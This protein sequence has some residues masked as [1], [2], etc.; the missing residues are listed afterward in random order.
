MFLWQN[1]REKSKCACS[2]ASQGSWINLPRSQWQKI[3]NT[4]LSSLFCFRWTEGGKRGGKSISH[5]YLYSFSTYDAFLQSSFQRT[6]MLDIRV[7]EK[8][9][10][11]NSW[12]LCNHTQSDIYLLLNFFLVVIGRD[13]IE[14]RYVYAC[15]NNSSQTWPQI[16]NYFISSDWF[17]K[18]NVSVWL[19]DHSDENKKLRVWMCICRKHFC[20]W[21]NLPPNRCSSTGW[22]EQGGKEIH[23]L[24]SNITNRQCCNN[25]TGT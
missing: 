2:E 25:A 11:K 1:Q 19:K 12:R 13:E 20:R 18:R 21:Y 8:L 14:P 10:S 9:H 4:Y 5:H 3:S 16:F 22:K 7:W 15:K 24:A 17:L 6:F 23:S